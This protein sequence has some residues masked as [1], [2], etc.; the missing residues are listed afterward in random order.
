MSFYLFHI[1]DMFHFFSLHLRIKH[2][3]VV[4]EKTVGGHDQPIA[5][6]QDFFKKGLYR[7]GK[8]KNS[9]KLVI[10]IIRLNKVI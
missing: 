5:R 4:Q 8:K 7:K 6:L 2:Q 9:V 10:T 3:A 1:R